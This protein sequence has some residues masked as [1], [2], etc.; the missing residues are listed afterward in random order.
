MY[1][2]VLFKNKVKKKIIKEFKTIKKA[3]DYYKLLMDVSD[4]VIFDKQFDN[5]Y[6]SNYELAF[7]QPKTDKFSSL[8]V[9]D[10]FGRQIKIEME[11]G[12]NII[13]KINQYNIDEVFLDYSTKKKIN[14]SSFIK[15]YLDPI[16]LKLVSKLNNKIIVQNDDSYNLFTFKNDSDSSRFIDNIS[17]HFVKSKRMDCLFVK[18][19]DTNQRKYLYS[20]LVEKGFSKSYLFRQSTTHP[21]KK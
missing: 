1:I 4:T 5:G 16:G 2:I 21:T 20:V 3:E 10:D 18:D 17:S 13:T 8:Y 11:S 9:K 7:L 14:T 15:K 19:Y 12:D 6:E